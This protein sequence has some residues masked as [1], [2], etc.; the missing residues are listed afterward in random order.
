[1]AVEQTINTEIGVPV[2]GAYGRPIEHKNYRLGTAEGAPLEYR[3]LTVFGFWLSKANSD[4]HRISGVPA[5][6]YTSGVS[7]SYDPT[8]RQDVQAYAAWM[9]VNPTAIAV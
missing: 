1:M 5:P 8:Q 6:I 2:M 3:G 9:L 4:A 7:Y